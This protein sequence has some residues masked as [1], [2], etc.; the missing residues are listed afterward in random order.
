MYTHSCQADGL[1]PRLGDAV[2]NKGRDKMTKTEAQA[3]MERH[4]R[5]EAGDGNDRDWG[6]IHSI[7]GDTAIVGWESGVRTP[8]AIADITFA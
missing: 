5:I 3:A 4:T 1:I 7:G 2:G 8:C 6:Y